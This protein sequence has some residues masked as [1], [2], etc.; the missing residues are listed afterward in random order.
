M[1]GCSFAFD[2]NSVS[3][4]DAGSF[5]YF[6]GFEKAFDITRLIF[7]KI[8][9][10]YKWKTIGAE[11]F[12]LGRTVTQYFKFPHYKTGFNVFYDIQ[13]SAKAYKPPCWVKALKL[14]CR[15]VLVRS[16]DIPTA[17]SATLPF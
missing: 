10:L 15:H 16:F 17:A 14:F 1:S 6:V 2:I 7:P 8:P 9:L 13:S 3:P 12:V 11:D 5:L 4:F